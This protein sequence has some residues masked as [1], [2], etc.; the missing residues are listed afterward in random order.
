M[1]EKYGLS[2]TASGTPIAARTSATTASR[3]FSM[4][5][6]RAV[7]VG[8]HAV[9][10]E[11]DRVGAGVGQQRGVAHPSAGG[12]G[13]QAGNHRYVDRGFDHRQC[14][15]VALAGVGEPGDVGEVVQRF[16]EVLT[17]GFECND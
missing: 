17:A 4:S 10:V 14:L 16:G 8:G 5:R 2:F 6:G 1:D 12:G 13:V 15:D 7:G 3:S 11:L 9:E